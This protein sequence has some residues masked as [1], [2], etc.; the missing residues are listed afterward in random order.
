[1]KIAVIALISLMPI[2]AQEIKLPP[3]LDRLA[4]KA[5]EVVDVTLDASMLQLASRFLS[6]KDPDGAKIKKLAS[7]L[8]GIW[9]KSFEFDKAGE[10][11]ESDVEAVRSQLRA[12]GWARIVGVRSQK[13][14]EN[15]EIFLRTEAGHITGLTIVSAEPKQ[16]TIVHI[17]GSI[18]PEQLAELGGHFGIPKIGKATGAERKSADKAGKE[19]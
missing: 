4:A 9:V 3:S 17:A 14:A 16:L 6:D 15:S 7:G 10:Y 8:K 13:N 11:L 19:E 5:T 12:P 18:N 1:M 2:L